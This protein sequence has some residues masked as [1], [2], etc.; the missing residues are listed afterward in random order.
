MIH[1]LFRAPRTRLLLVVLFCGALMSACSR[2]PQVRKQKFYKTGVEYLNKGD[3]KKAALQFMN[4]LQIDPKFAEAAN[5]LAEIEFRQKN[6]RRAYSLL[7]QAIAA[8]PDYLP[9]HK[10]LAQIYRLA[11]KTA[12]AEKELQFIL[13][14]SPDDVEALLN[15][16]V[17]QTQ[18][19][20]LADAEGTLNRVLELQPNHVGA[21][22]ALATLK[23]DAH[24]LP[25]AERYLKLAVDKNPRS[26][27]VQLTLIKF[28]ITT[29][30]AAEAE[31]LF[32]Q[33]LRMSNNNVVVLEAQAGYYEGLKKYV[34]AEKVAKTIQSSHANDPEYWGALGDF[35]VRIGDWPRAKSEMERVYQQHNDDPAALHKLIE[36]Y[37][38][39]N[40]RRTAENLNGALLKKNPQDSYGHLFRGRM[41]LADGNVDKALVEFNETA[42]YLLD[43]TA[44]HYWLAQ[45][46]IQ[47]GDLQ[48]ARQELEIA[49]R[50]EP[51]S[52]VALLSLAKLDSATG[53]VD[54]ALSESRRLAMN[55]PGDVD[56]MLLY[57]Q[58]L[59]KK[60][61]YADA[62]KVL[63]ALLER[64]PA[65]AEAHRLSGVLYLAHQDLAGARKEFKQAWELQPQSKSLLENVVLGYFVAKQPDAAVDFLQEE[66]KARPG[67]AL[68]YRELGQVYLWEKK[69]SAAIPVLQKAL[70]LAPADAD[71]T[72]LLADSY[73]AEKK[74][75]ESVRLLSAAMQQHPTD[76]GLMLQSGMIYEKLQRWDDARGCY[77]R[78]LQLDGDNALA[79][80]NLA[81]LLVEHG[82]NIDLAL[83]LAQ[84]AKEK[85]YDNPQVTDTIGWVY[86]KK[87]VYKT[88][89]DYLKQSVEK[90]QKNPTFQYQLGMAEQKLGNQDAAR[91][92]LLN[93]IALDPQS[94]EAALARSALAPQ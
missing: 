9:P 37:L 78:A 11:G 40:D 91:R 38:T 46:H 39:L 16:G 68:L 87:G 77:E 29:G 17:L 79:K 34:E 23:R 94:P 19:K 53:M 35:Y 30:R 6:Y 8:K 10:G 36:V 80:N 20:K 24:D 89:R 47:K 32:S 41:Y 72:I 82:G 51:N 48:Q 70:S 54:R 85:L 13:S 14:H 67:D 56:S 33:A 61:D 26:V 7:Q 65:N 71:S 81:W 12:D 76:A 83:T 69:R 31:P 88:A 60:G 44:L 15:L 25:A 28:Y 58:S 63:K 50:Y 62:E 75:D 57:C 59:L 49:L 5:V 74:S 43:S 27:P 2:D 45:A 93:A 90:D 1:R 92:D 42:K 86:Y 73:A 3:T 21:M 55:K 64:A 52:Q 84:Q 18:Q 66:I 22:V 4:A